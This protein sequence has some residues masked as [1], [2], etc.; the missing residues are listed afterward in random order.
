MIAALA[1]GGLLCPELVDRRA[2][3]GGLPFALQ[4][5]GS[6]SPRIWKQDV[7]HELERRRRPFDVEEER[8][9]VKG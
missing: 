8:S 9:C 3:R 6:M 1:V 2:A 4:I 5:S 7:V